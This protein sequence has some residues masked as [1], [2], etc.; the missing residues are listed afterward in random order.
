MYYWDNEE[1]LN[2]K[3]IDQDLYYCL[4]CNPQ[5]F[6]ISDIQEVLAVWEGENDGDDWRWLIKLTA[7]ASKEKAENKRF[8]FLQGGCDYTG[9]DCQSWATS[10]FDTT[11]LKVAKFAFEKDVPLTDGS[12][13]EAGLGHMLSILS[14]GYI[15]TA[16]KAYDDL[17]KQIKSGK[18]KTWRE[19]TGEALG[20]KDIPKIG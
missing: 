16:Q 15:D 7:K 19:E 10:I 18:R 6:D 13:Y 2:E 20:T 4:S 9:W 11:A 17:V 14:G 1:E 5:P 3:G 12:P 8:A